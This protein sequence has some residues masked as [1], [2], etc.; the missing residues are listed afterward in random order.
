MI[1]THVSPL[2]NDLWKRWLSEYSTFIRDHFNKEK[3]ESNWPYL[4]KVVL[5]H[6]NGRRLFWKMAIMT[7][8]MVE[9][10]VG[11]GQLKLKSLPDLRLDL[12]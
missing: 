2:S 8:Y 11:I 12:L 3:V 10:T 7:N 6:N 4:G 1:I 9:M 5:I